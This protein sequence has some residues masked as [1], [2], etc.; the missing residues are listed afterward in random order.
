[1]YVRHMLTYATHQP[2]GIVASALIRA[3]VKQSSEHI[4]LATQ[5]S[6]PS[7]RNPVR[8]AAAR[9][10]VRSF[11]VRQQMANSTISTRGEGDARQRA[12]KGGE[13]PSPSFQAGAGRGEGETE[14]I[15][16]ERRA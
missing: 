8:G 3:H 4:T 2:H 16:S 10:L 11:A 12:D 13:S 9:P 1:M 6:L 15:A 14:R 5:T 7:T